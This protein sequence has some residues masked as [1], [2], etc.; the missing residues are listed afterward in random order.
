MVIRLLECFEQF[1]TLP[2]DASR[3]GGDLKSGL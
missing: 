3:S 1:S 2:R